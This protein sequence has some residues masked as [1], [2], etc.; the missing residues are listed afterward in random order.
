MIVYLDSMIVISLNLSAAI[1]NGCGLFLTNDTRL[2]R[3]TEIPV[4]VLA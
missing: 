2:S 3:C 1:E 4:E